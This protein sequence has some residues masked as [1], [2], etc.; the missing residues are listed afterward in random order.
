MEDQGHSFRHET[1]HDSVDSCQ[2][3]NKWNSH[4]MCSWLSERVSLQVHM[5]DRDFFI[6]RVPKCRPQ[7]RRR[8]P[9]QVQLD[10]QNLSQAY[11][12]IQDW[13]FHTWLLKLVLFNL[14]TPHPILQLQTDIHSPLATIAPAR[15]QPNRLQLHFQRHGQAHTNAMPNQVQ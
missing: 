7:R 15:L 3:V 13:R 6:W 1:S 8:N 14:V 4:D 5:L 10:P 11:H 9:H 12:G 2:A